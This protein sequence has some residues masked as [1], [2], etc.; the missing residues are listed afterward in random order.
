MNYY[1]ENT[2]TRY[3]TKL[4]GSINLSGDWE[5]GLSEIIFPHSWLTLDKSDA[6][7]TVSMADFSVTNT[8][9]AHPPLTTEVRFP[10]GYY[11]SV[12]DIVQEMNKALSKNGSSSSAA[13]G[14]NANRED[15]LM[16]SGAHHSNKEDN[17]MPRIKYNSSSRRVHFNMYRNQ[18]LTFSPTLA[19]IL[20]LSAKQNPSATKN[21]ETFNWIGS[22][23]SD[24]TRGMNYIM[25]YCDLLEPVPV[26]DTKAPLL[27]IIDAKGANGEML[28][29]SF[30]D[31]RYIPLQKR[32]FDSIEL[33]I[34]D[35]L[36]KPIPFESGKLVVTL[37]FRQA[38]SPYF[39]N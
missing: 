38:K 22:G 29:R 20:G 30:D 28:H 5:V 6:S 26:G 37:H 11:D 7:F 19:T 32:N 3:V 13:N 36:G 16:R 27:R 15:N 8:A 23:V 34:R 25:L 4:H 12:Q 31:A 14:Q 21:E 17:Q 24:I 35:D 9:T 39:L 1:H 2:L 10:Y 33:D 18:S